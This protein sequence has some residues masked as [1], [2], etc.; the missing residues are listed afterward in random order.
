ML[1]HTTTHSQ[2]HTHRY[3]QK[4]AHKHTCK[5]TNVTHTHK[6][7]EKNDFPNEHASFNCGYRRV[8]CQL[9]GFCFVKHPHNTLSLSL[10]FPPSLSFSLSF[11]LSLSPSLSPFLPLSLSLS[12]PPS[13]FLSLFLSLSPLSSLSLFL[14]LSLSLFLSISPSLP[15]SLSL[16]VTYFPFDWQNCTMV[17]RSYTYDSSEID[18]QYALDRKGK[19]IQEIVYD[20]T[21][22]G[23]Q[24]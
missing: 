8:L 3:R 13:L 17:F 10:S 12:F 7:Q 20:H 4:Y 6:R 15:L 9:F 22:S 1:T 24:W 5:W 23:E 2:I 11:S 18:L 21:F 14:S 19:E 16:Q